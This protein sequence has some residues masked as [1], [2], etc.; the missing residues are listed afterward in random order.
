VVKSVSTIGNY[1]TFIQPH[2][3][4]SEIPNTS[5]YLDYN[6]EYIFYLDG[7]I[8]VK[9]RASG[10]IFSAFFDEASRADLGDFGEDEYGYKVHD[11]ISGSMHDHVLN[12]KADLDIG[13]QQN[14]L[15]R[16]DIEA[17]NKTFPWDSEIE[18]PRHTMHLSTVP[19]TEEAGLDWPKNSA[20]MYIVHGND[21]RNRWGEKRGY[22]I[23]PG[24]GM[25]TP[26]KLTIHNSTNL[27]T[28]TQWASHNLWA[29]RQKDSEPKS[30]H[31]RNVLNP[32][33]PMVNFS[34][35]VDGESIVEEDL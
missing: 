6:I 20:G 18:S 16:V 35:F 12:F 30:A 33:D 32:G 27:E 14:S 7:T 4:E 1:G 19:I 26:P 3:R 28:A 10:Y 8:E 25:G 24:T 29:L 5:H 34:T 21:T 11:V 9:V 31:E 22:R 17:T 2:S 15:V 23:A 13:G